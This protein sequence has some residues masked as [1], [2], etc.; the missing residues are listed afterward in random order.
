[1]AA[2]DA[3]A[4]ESGK[5][6]GAKSSDLFRASSIGIL[7]AV[8]DCGN[9]FRTNALFCDQCGAK[10]KFA[11]VG[12]GRCACGSVIVEG[13]NYCLMC[14]APYKR[15]GQAKALSPQGRQ[16]LSPSHAAVQRHAVHPAPCK[17]GSVKDGLFKTLDRNQDG[18][19]SRS[20]FLSAL[21]GG[22]ISPAEEECTPVP[23]PSPQEALTRMASVTSLPGNVSA[24]GGTVSPSKGQRE[25][26]GE[27]RGD[28]GQERSVD[29]SLLQ[30]HLCDAE[31]RR[32]CLRKEQEDLREENKALHEAV[33][34]AKRDVEARLCKKRAENVALIADNKELESM[35]AEA[36][37]I[38]DRR[39]VIRPKRLEFAEEWETLKHEKEA[40]QRRV[41]WLAPRPVR[42]PPGAGM[43]SPRSMESSAQATPRIEAV[44][45][46]RVLAALQKV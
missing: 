3:N 16:H 11:E 36:K 32:K 22:I 6:A 40:V 9:E 46:S 1:M 26:R 7:H 18:G 21:K 8:C 4:P 14:G 28:V 24:I 42:T 41:E 34:K 37:R 19:I 33:A 5:L 35:T 13:A 38:N 15:G 12:P 10:R 44:T 45:N 2:R 17:V 29:V 25:Q 20:E 30:R 39:A 43:V 31:E 23:A 27:G